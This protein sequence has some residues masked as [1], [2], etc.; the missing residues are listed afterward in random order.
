MKGNTRTQIGKLMKW[1]YLNKS[2]GYKRSAVS[3]EGNKEILFE[4]I[5]RK[6]LRES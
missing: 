4:F 5:G 1:K 3:K 6:A 2:E